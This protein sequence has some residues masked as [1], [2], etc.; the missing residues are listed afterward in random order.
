MVLP[1]L[2]LQL[3]TIANLTLERQSIHDSVA[4]RS[5]W[6]SSYDYII[7]GAGT[8]GAVVASRLSEVNEWKVLLIEA[9]DKETVLTDMLGAY[10]YTL[11][12]PTISWGYKSVPQLYVN[13]SIFSATRTKQL[14]GSSSQNGI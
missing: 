5:T 14:G 11:W 8:A 13:N 10:W 6:D 12:E 3:L 7:V 4:K 2:A 1:T 9:G